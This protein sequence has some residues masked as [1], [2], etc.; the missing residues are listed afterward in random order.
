MAAYNGIY[1]AVQLAGIAHRQ[2]R[3]ARGRRRWFTLALAFI[4]AALAVGVYTAFFSGPANKTTSK[5][6][7]PELSFEA[8]QLTDVALV[9]GAVG[10]YAEANDALPTRLSVAPGGSL[11]LCGA[12]CSISYEVGGLSV[13]QASDIRLMEYASGLTVPNQNFMYLVPSATCSSGG[14]LGTQNPS[15]RSMVILYDTVSGSS[16]APRCI[17]L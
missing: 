13:Y 9:G 5:T 8:R 15:A 3:N 4:V 11:I 6:G 1:M 16:T 12:T 14:Q 10:Q 17:V 7:Q 2:S